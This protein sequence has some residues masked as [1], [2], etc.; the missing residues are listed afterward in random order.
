MIAHEGVIYQV[1]VEN[2]KISSGLQLNSNPY[3]IDQRWPGG[4]LH[5]IDGVVV[6]VLIV[7]SMC[8]TGRSAGDGG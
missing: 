2:I 4:F 6:K 3:S 5:D 8:L 7:F 1:M